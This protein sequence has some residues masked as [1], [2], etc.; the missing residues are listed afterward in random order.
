M[1]N[2]AHLTDALLQVERQ[3]VRL[4]LLHQLRLAPGKN[5]ARARDTTARKTRVAATYSAICPIAA[6]S[7]LSPPP[8]AGVAGT[9]PP[10]PREASASWSDRAERCRGTRVA[11]GRA[12][13][14]GLS[15]HSASPARVGWKPLELLPSLR[16]QTRGPRGI[17]DYVPKAS[18]SSEAKGQESSAGSLL[19]MDSRTEASAKSSTIT[20]PTAVAM[21]RAT[22]T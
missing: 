22:A 8:N 13:Y 21:A 4:L 10:T 5:T 11:G 2:R 19:L 14:Q 18:S 1:K 6:A 3:G 9:A 17:S 16:G 15:L 12:A 20:E 7:S